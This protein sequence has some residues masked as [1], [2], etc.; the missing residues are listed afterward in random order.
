M[1]F[2]TCFCIV[3]ASLASVLHAAPEFLGGTAPRTA[4]ALESYAIR[5]PV[6][7][8]P[9]IDLANP[10]F[11]LATSQVTFTDSSNQFDADV[12]NNVIYVNVSNSLFVGEWAV[13]ITLAGAVSLKL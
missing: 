9:V 8:Y 13:S 2:R 5:R 4:F 7:F 6:A 1:D 10:T 12:I 11:E 3:L